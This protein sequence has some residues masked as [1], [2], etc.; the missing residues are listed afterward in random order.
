M[1]EL[2]ENEQSMELIIDYMESSA[3]GVKMLYD[4]MKNMQVE[5]RSEL[6]EVREVQ[7]SLKKNITLAR[8]EEHKLHSAVLS[9]SVALTHKFFK[10]K[11][12]EELFNAKRGHTTSYVWI[13][14]KNHYDVSTYPQIPHI[15]FE[16]AMRMVDRLQVEDFPEAY[17]RLTPK[18]QE[19]AVKNNDQAYHIYFGEDS[20]QD[21]LF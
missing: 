17:Y 13:V 8:G 7:E 16:N 2:M 5:V 11:V 6:E 9:K 12:S 10:G 14:L 19:I 1:N 21:Y 15:E 20:N 4:S 18:M 3:K